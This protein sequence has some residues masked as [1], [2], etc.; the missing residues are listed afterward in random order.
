V[1]LADHA[2]VA[3]PGREGGIRRELIELWNGRA[4]RTMW[5]HE[6]AQLGD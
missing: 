2:T 4:G 5:S 1:I 3:K 6:L